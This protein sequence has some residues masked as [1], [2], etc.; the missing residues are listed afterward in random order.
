MNSDEAAAA[1][2][3]NLFLYKCLTWLDLCGSIVNCI[4]LRFYAHTQRDG[5]SLHNSYSSLFHHAVI[6]A[7]CVGKQAA[8]E[9]SKINLVKG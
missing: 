6:K 9:Q 5:R 1:V 8:L 2:S 4:I 3:R 7:V